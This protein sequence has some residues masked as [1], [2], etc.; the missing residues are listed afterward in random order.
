M[1]KKIRLR[2]GEM[3]DYTDCVPYGDAFRIRTENILDRSRQLFKV[4]LAIP[5]MPFWLFGLF[6]GVLKLLSE[7]GLLKDLVWRY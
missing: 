1:Q 4:S 5:G 3:M 2:E 7:M 6:Y